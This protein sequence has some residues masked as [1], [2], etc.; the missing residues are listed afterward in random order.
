VANYKHWFIDCK[1][2]GRRITLEIYTGAAI[3]G[4]RSAE[5]LRCPTCNQ[6]ATYSGDDFK[7]VEL[8][9]SATH[10]VG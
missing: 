5:K 4:N 10:G 8:Q 9:A 3:G 2:C 1:G 7:T 6:E